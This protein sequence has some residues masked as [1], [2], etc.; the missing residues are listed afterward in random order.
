MSFTGL[1][2]AVCFQPRFAFFG[3][4]VSVMSLPVRKRCYASRLILGAVQRWRSNLQLLVPFLERPRIE[5]LSL[6]ADPPACTVQ[7][8]LLDLNDSNMSGRLAA[9]GSMHAFL[10][11]PTDAVHAL[12]SA[13]QGKCGM[14]CHA[15]AATGHG[16]QA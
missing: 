5:L 10:P 13:N 6:A 16:A 4:M 15:A 9:D 12:Q 14:D 7:V 11:L 1:Q 3:V 8:W 2:V